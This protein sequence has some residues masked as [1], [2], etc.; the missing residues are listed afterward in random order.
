MLLRAL[1]LG[2]LLLAG[3][4]ACESKHFQSPARSLDDCF[5]EPWRPNC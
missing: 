5:W 3:L 4:T 2:S 1:L